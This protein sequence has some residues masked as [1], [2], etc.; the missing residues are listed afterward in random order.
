MLNNLIIRPE[1]PADYKEA[2]LMTMR[3]FWNK[4]WPGCRA[5]WQDCGCCLLHKSVDSGWGYQT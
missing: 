3:S 2:E 4:Y 5:G 1:N